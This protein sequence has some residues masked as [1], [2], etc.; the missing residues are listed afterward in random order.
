MIFLHISG[1]V[2][3][4]EQSK[5]AKMQWLQDPNQNN[6]DNWNN[7]KREGSRHFRN[8]KTEYPK[9]KFDELEIN[10]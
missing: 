9:A 5:Q 4:L 3:H 1:P 8:K 7:V 10:S 6:V 2:G